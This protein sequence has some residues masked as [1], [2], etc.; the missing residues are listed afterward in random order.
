MSKGIDRFADL[1][2]TR[3]QKNVN[4]K[5]PP[6]S[7][8]TP[9]EIAKIRSLMPTDVFL[10]EYARQLH[11]NRWKMLQA[12]TQ[13]TETQNSDSLRRIRD[14][15]KLGGQD[16]SGNADDDP[17]WPTSIL[18]CRSSRFELKCP[19]FTFGYSGVAKNLATGVN[20]LCNLR[21][22]MQFMFHFSYHFVFSG[23]GGQE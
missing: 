5:K 19:G 16:V 23:S 15:L 9:E 1:Y 20:L 12:E 21:C 13:N 11:R 2:L 18:G 22:M 7:E 14:R 6:T 3:E 10:Y 4:K 17:G 8:L